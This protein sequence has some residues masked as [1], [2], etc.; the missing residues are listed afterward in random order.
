MADER[1]QTEQE[2]RLLRVRRTKLPSFKR[3][4]RILSDLSMM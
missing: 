4:E 2:V 1:I 3:M